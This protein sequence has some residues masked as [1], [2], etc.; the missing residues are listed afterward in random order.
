MDRLTLEQTREM[1]IAVADH[2]IVHMDDLTEA[3][4]A[5]GDGD[6]GVGMATG[7][8]SGKRALREM[9]EPRGVG[10]LFRTM[11][12]QMMTAMGG[13][14][15]VI[16]GTMFSACARVGP[17]ANCLTPGALAGMM[18]ASLDAVK[19]RGKARLGD[20]TMVDA[21]EPAVEAM[22]HTDQAAF[23]PMLELAEAAALAGVED[24]KGYVARFGRAKSL[25][26]RCLGHQDAGATSVWLIF[27]AMHLFVR[28]LE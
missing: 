2:L 28:K 21:L 18:R 24:T 7:A 9:G 15:G 19:E 8:E 12:I 10:Q 6:H 11:G 16:F 22:E 20:K 17:E 4:A 23:L 1:L 14:S 26:Q 25:Q 13:A 5:I 27:Q 3:D